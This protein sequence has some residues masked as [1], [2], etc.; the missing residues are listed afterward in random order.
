MPDVEEEV[1]SGVVPMDFEHGITF[2][3]IPFGEEGLEVNTGDLFEDLLHIGAVCIGLS[4]LEE[5]L[6]DS[7]EKEAVVVNDGA[8]AVDD[9]SAFVVGKSG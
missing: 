3:V 2:A 5:E 8:E 1:V 4:E 9:G 6:L 7:G